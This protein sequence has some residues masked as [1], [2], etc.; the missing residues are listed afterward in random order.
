MP[1]EVIE[2]ELDVFINEV[3][4][5]TKLLRHYDKEKYGENPKVNLIGHSMGGMVITGYL[6]R[7]GTQAPVNKVVTLATPF[8]G[9]F[10][11]VLKIST[12]TANL[13]TTSQGSRERESARITPALYYLLPSFKSGITVAPGVPDSLYDPGAWQPTIIDSIKEFIRLKGLPSRVI[14]PLDIFSGL[15]ERAKKHSQMIEQ[16]T[17]EQAGLDS[18]RWLA[19]VGVNSETRVKLNIIKRNGKVDFDIK[20]ADRMNKWEDDDQTL[21]RLTG[22]GTVPYEGAV[23]PF[24]KEENLVCVTPQDYGYWEVQDRA[25]S[26]LAG[27]HGIL[28]NMNMLHRLIVRFLKEKDDKRGNTWGQKAPGVVTWDPPLKLQ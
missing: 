19:V 3:I 14:S 4:E 6:N 5:R 7:K 17:L 1:L 21:R 13:G 26:K 10:E 24:L 16:F 28:P 18:K 20:S 23:P 22:D 25:V 15:L 12:G 9:S 2:D 27:F 11:A 8:R